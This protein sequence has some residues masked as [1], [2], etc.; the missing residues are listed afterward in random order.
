[1]VQQSIVKQLRRIEGQI[2]GVIGMIETDRGLVPTVQQFLATQASL[3][4]SMRNYVSSFLDRGDGDEIVLTPDQ[5]KYILN[6]ISK[7]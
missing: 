5:L 4:S 7:K 3:D 1:M 6:L 2:R